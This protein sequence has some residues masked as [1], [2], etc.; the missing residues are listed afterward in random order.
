FHK[1]PYSIPFPR[2]KA[3]YKFLAVFLGATLLSIVMI[4]D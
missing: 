4:W 1:C 3:I 2:D